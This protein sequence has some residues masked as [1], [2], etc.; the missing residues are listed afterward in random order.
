M[1]LP[2]VKL[3]I[4]VGG[5]SKGTRFRP[6]SMDTPKPLFPVS[7]KP[8][9]WHHV[10]ASCASLNGKAD[11]REILLIGFYDGKNPEWSK[12]ISNVEAEFKV[13]VRYLQEEG[14]TGT[15]GGIIRFRNEIQSGSP[16][17]FYVEHCDVVCSFPLA[18]LLQS[19]QSSGKDITI[20][21]KRVPSDQAHRYGCIVVHPE[22]HEVIHY[23][24]K[25]ETFISDIINCGV[26][27]FS[28][29]SFFDLV[30]KVRQN[31]KREPGSDPN[32]FQLEQDLFMPV[33]HNK[34]IN[35]FLSQEF[36]IQLKSAGM[37]IKCHEHFMRVNAEK[38]KLAKSGFQVQGNVMVDPTAKIDPSAKL[39]PNVSIGAGVVI[40]PGVRISNSIVL[41]NS[42]IKER[43][44][45]L[46]SVVG[47][48]CTIGKWARLEGVPDFSAQGDDKSNGITILG[49]GVTVANET[50]IRA[51]IVLPHKELSG[52]YA[53]QIL[54]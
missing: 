2:K 41:D 46:Y 31:S 12:F 9:V 36:W 1:S 11:L 52:S 24:E 14:R 33:S 29:T 43:S 38:L 28:T 53:D 35:C 42:E 23:A 26:Y 6:L 5:P 32:S 51:S 20:L 3:V 37:V 19:H 47:W 17:Y 7:D 25:P 48:K 8:L 30:E 49:N 54:L 27:L 13:P 39:G 4:L 50:V 21:G 34:A 10:S 45:I 15:G 22:S 44:C 16:D 40:G 18:D